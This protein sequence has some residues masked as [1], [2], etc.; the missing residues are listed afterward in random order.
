MTTIVVDGGPKNAWHDPETG[1]R[2]YGWQG[3]TLVS[4]T[5]ARN[6]AG[7]PYNLL[8][9]Y[10]A[11]ICDR[12][13]DE[14]PTLVSMMERPRRPRERSLEKNRREEARRWL[15]AAPDEIRDYKALR[16]TGVHEAARL[17]M[18]P[19]DVDDFREVRLRLP[20]LDDAGAVLLRKD[21]SPRVHTI[22]RRSFGR[23]DVPDGAEVLSELVVPASEIRDRLRHFFAWLEE[24]GAEI[25]LSEFQVFNLAL[26]YGGS[27][28]I[29]CRF[30][31]G[32]LWIIDLKTGDEAY[33]DYLLQQ[34]AYLMAEFIGADDVIDEAATALLHQVAGVALLHLADDGWEFK[35]LRIDARAW[36]A[37][38]GL[39]TFATWTSE[40]PDED[41]FLVAT[42]SGSADSGE[43]EAA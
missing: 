16:G 29:L 22:E 20:L 37:F 17:G 1:L 25:L 38:R 26:G 11:R 24:S 28:D 41:S 32:E 7:V 2:H 3:R 42:K 18:A 8:R 21:G 10:A 43:A 13:T 19:A 4:V 15:R 9:W 23:L 40:H 39:L 34:V 30:P 27:G 14:L 35:R 33:S 5:S 31:N 6:M 12:A 36:A